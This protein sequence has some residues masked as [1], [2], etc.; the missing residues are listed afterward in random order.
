MKGF[1]G[2]MRRGPQPLDAATVAHFSECLGT[3]SVRTPCVAVYANGWASTYT[4]ADGLTVVGIA[5]RVEG[6]RGP[7]DVVSASSLEAIAALYRTYGADAC[8]HLP[9]QFCV[10]IYDATAERL[11]IA[12]D[13][14]ATRVIYYAEDGDILWFSSALAWLPREL[15]GRLDEQALLEYLLYSVVPHS[16]TPYTRVCKLAPGHVLSADRS[17]VRTR[18]YWDMTYPEERNGRSTTEWAQLLRGEIESAVRRVVSGVSGNSVGAFLSGGTDSSTVAGMMSLITGEPA[19]TFSIGYAE[20]QYDELSYAR[21]A[22]SWFGLDAHEHLLTAAEAFAALPAIVGYYEEPFGNASALAT[23]SC[24]QQARA[25]G[26]Q[27]LLAG[28]GG[29]ELFAGNERYRT[30]E[31]FALYQRLPQVLRRLA[32]PVFGILPDQLPG[33]GHARRYVRR[34]NVPN[35]RR[36]FSYN[37]VLTE[38]LPQLLAADF[39]ASIDPAQLLACAEAHFHRLPATTS[40]L[41]RLLY[42]DLKLAIADND[43]RKVSGMA[44]LAGI[45]V[46]YP[47]LDAGLAEFSGRIPTPLKV[48]GLQKRYLFKQALADFLPPVILNKPKH[49][50]GVPIALWMKADRQWSELTADVL[51]DRRTRER[52]YLQPAV[53]DS[54]WTQHQSAQSAYYGDLLWPVL[55]LEL[56]H[57][58]HVDHAA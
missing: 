20:D 25:R 10:A 41:N 54:L 45:E 9:D 43:V 34:S 23:Y 30:N 46:R 44:E 7:R 14:F 18:A 8:A 36:F 27:V 35:P 21:A 5:E 19:K 50:F 40:E 32:N 2:V 51:H 26:L 57:R 24:A 48:H 56:W 37:L 49:G 16:R 1:C 42:V 15:R 22:A 33:F 12:T 28:D 55:M 29:D 31:I 3:P 52:G 13:R 6:N 53:I 39:L 58:E 47:F 11:L 17:A 4:A 38:P